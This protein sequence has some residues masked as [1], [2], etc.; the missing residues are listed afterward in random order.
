[1]KGLIITYYYYNRKIISLNLFLFTSY[2]AANLPSEFPAEPLTIKDNLKKA[3]LLLS[4]N[5]SDFVSVRENVFKFN[6]YYI[7]V[8]NKYC[9]CKR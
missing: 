3:D 1:M 2:Y 5:F 6:N 8:A 9:N 4:K 7:D